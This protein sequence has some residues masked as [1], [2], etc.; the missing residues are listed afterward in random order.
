[1]LEFILG[2]NERKGNIVGIF[3]ITIF[4]Y[5]KHL[6]RVFR[7]TKYLEEIHYIQLKRNIS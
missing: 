6:I 4:R 1:M 3:G 2:E 5:S 7:E